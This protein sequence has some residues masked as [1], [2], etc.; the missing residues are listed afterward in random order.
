MC[1]YVKILPLPCHIVSQFS[2]YGQAKP[3]FLNKVIMQS[4]AWVPASS[5]LQ[6]KIISRKGFWRHEYWVEQKQSNVCETEMSPSIWALVQKTR[7]GFNY[8]EVISDIKIQTGKLIQSWRIY[9]ILEL[10]E[11]RIIILNDSLHF[12]Q[13]SQQIS[14]EHLLYACNSSTNL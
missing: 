2:P 3:I 7:A 12:I 9:K 8:V 5:F 11:T 6:G 10:A 13:S 1:S 14:D 4:V